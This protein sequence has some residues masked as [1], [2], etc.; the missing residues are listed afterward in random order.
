MNH[1]EKLAAAA[2]AATDNPLLCRSAIAFVALLS[3]FLPW[4]TFDGNS[5]GHSGATLAANM[6]HG[7]DRGEM[8]ST[9]FTAAIAVITLPFLAMAAAIIATFQ[10]VRGYDILALNIGIILIV[11]LLLIGSAPLTST[12]HTMMFGWTQPNWGLILL[13]L[14]NLTLG[15]HT[16]WYKFSTASTGHWDQPKDEEEPAPPPR[17]PQQP[18]QP[19]YQHPAT[20]SRTV[21]H[22]Q[23]PTR[24][25]DAPRQHITYA[26]E[27]PPTQPQD[28]AET[29][30][31]PP[32]QPPPQT[33]PRPKARMPAGRRKKFSERMSRR[34][35][36]GPDSRGR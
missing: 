13:L 3:F 21:G 14:C 23:I 32:Q 26:S 5:G 12:S 2:A 20:G 9:S 24:T 7:T 19:V 10:T 16:I 28:H 31:P 18:E 8:F 33:S 1:K 30:Q 25:A 35:P 29:P 36:Q 22:A 6:L 17:Q 15:A 4:I 11:L 34:Y 27:A